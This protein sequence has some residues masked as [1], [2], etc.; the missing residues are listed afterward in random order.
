MDKTCSERTEAVVETREG[1]HFPFARE[2]F[3]LI[4]IGLVG[5]IFGLAFKLYG[6]AGIFLLF[7]LFSL[8]FFRDPRRCLKTGPGII[9]SPAD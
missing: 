1:F 7:T 8:Y 6:F 4:G 3:F 5:M 9:L 2:G